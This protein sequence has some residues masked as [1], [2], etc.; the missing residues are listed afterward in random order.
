MNTCHC[1]YCGS[2][3]S[4]TV[5]STN[6]YPLNEQLKVRDKSN[7]NCPSCGASVRERQ[8]KFYFDSTKLLEGRSNIRI[9]HFKPESKF[10][11]YLA[12]LNPEVHILAM[13]EAIDLRYES[14]NIEDIPYSDGVFD[15]VIANDQ[16]ESVA[17]VEK[18]LNE[19]T[20]VL[21]P[22]GFLLI[23]TSFSESL[24][25]TWEDNDL[26]YKTL[27]ASAF[28][29][30]SH[31][32]IFG[33]D[34]F[35]LLSRKL[36]NKILRF[37]SP[38]SLGN[39]HALDINDPFMLFTKISTEVC[40]PSLP[41]FKLDQEVS[42]S[43]VCVTFNH[44]AFIDQT[45]LSFIQQQTN[46]RFEIVIGEDCSSDDTLNIILKWR[47]RY[48]E[49][50][51]LLTGSPNMGPH[52]NWNRA[53]SACSGSYIALCEGDDLWTDPF[54]LQ[55]QF[56]YM[57]AHPNCA[58][59]YGNVQAH[60]NGRIQYDYLGGL[61]VDLTADLLQ[62]SPPINTMTVMFRNVLGDMPPEKL[63]CGAGDMFLWSML[64]QHGYGHYMPNILPSIYNMHSGGMHSL[65]GAANQHLLRLKTY[66][67]AFH[68]YLRISCNDLADYF[69]QGVI[70]DAL[71]IASIST[72]EQAKLLLESAV[73]DMSLA[74]RDAQ[75]LDTS[76][77]SAIVDK[78]ISQLEICNAN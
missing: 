8:L 20:R 14:I 3:L 37:S 29:D 63:V 28:G 11:N 54:K 7:N 53:Y 26:D 45:L 1:N 40:T 71:H 36:N 72:P 35:D 10:L 48:P 42:V 69:L 57:E 16:L 5:E 30:E 70:K 55:K 56:D 62:K 17:S 31:R 64:G 46:F 6:T 74:I 39:K 32:R 73:S 76:A 27:H 13:T 50:I 21:K 2:V 78:V 12:A 77:L 65:T 4:P 15:L 58:M 38:P 19:L 59:T 60:K 47:D 49:V 66:Y 52:L 68:Y 22:D 44:A 25:T 24:D 75:I 51:K 43:I 34:I 41:K 23:Q 18:T 33:K 61:R 67:A 9:L